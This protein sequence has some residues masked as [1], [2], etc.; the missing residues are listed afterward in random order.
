MAQSTITDGHYT[1]GSASGKKEPISPCPT[2]TCGLPYPQGR[3]DERGERDG[4]PEVEETV[5]EDGDSGL[6]PDPEY[7]EGGEHGS[8]EHAD[9]ARCQRERAGRRGYAVGY[10]QLACA[11]MHPDREEHK[12]ETRGVEHPVAERETAPPHYLERAATG[13]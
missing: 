5:P 2:S 7:G 10:E 8:F 1:P 3:V 11:R 9:A 13:L 4:H 12:Y 6:S